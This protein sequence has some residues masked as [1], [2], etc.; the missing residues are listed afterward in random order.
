[1]KAK[2]LVI[3]QDDTIYLDNNFLEKAISTLEQFPEVVYYA[4]QCQNGIS[5]SDKDIKVNGMNIWASWP[6]H[7]HWANVVFRYDM[8]LKYLLS[9]ERKDCHTGDSLLLVRLAMKGDVF[10]T[11]DVTMNTNYQKVAS[12]YSGYFKD[13]SEEFQALQKCHQLLVESAIQHGV[14]KE[15]AD[16]WLI[17]QQIILARDCLRTMPK[18]KELMKKFIA[19]LHDYD[20]N[21]LTAVLDMIF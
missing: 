17:R 8:V 19:S 9:N 13:S 6:M 12:G 2:Y 14:N 10:I 1:M 3:L 16:N 7:M 5:F 21:V 18:D 4:G 15:F 11:K 20:K